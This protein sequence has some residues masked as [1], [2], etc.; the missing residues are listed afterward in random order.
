VTTLIGVV[1]KDETAAILNERLAHHD[2]ASAVVIDP[3]RPTSKKTRLVAQQQQIVRVDLEKRH[4]IAGAAAD[5][6]RRA[7]DHAI[8]GAHAC[9]L[10]D[11]AKGVL[12]GEIT[13]HAI[14][15]ARAAGVPVIVDPKQR[16][17]AVYRG[18]TVITP[19]LH[20]LEAA[21]HGL[22]PFEIE[23]AAERVLPEIGG[24]ALLVTRSA[25]G[26]TLFRAGRE[27]FHVAALAKEVF[28]VTG[29]GDTVVAT[30]ALALAARVAIEQA[31]AVASIA[32]A[33]SVSKRGT[34]T[35]S[36]GE[37]TSAIDAAPG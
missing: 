28:D 24:A 7:I 1:G 29:A 35:V 12:T 3:E 26:M 9:V 6:V 4:P 15:A 16:S 21:A 36:P 18:A 34:S 13:R 30:L 14:D 5:G 8:P 22:L 37:L 17:F 10:S 32:A 31:V 19:N 11:Y 2:I 27:P 23:R 20:E 33:I 25:D